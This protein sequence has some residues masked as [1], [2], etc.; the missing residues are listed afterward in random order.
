MY[1]KCFFSL[2]LSLYFAFL[3]LYLSY[4][5]IFL[6]LC[7]SISLSFSPSVL[8]SLFPPLYLIVCLSLFFVCVH[9]SL[10]LP[11]Y[12]SISLYLYIYPQTLIV[13]VFLYITF[14]NPIFSIS[15]GHVLKSGDYLTSVLTSPPKSL[16]LSSQLSYVISFTS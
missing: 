7:F 6:S 14:K 10:H 5:F 4:F 9:L 11:L 8:P 13:N 2:P 3:S 15:S 1:D 12:L 16:E